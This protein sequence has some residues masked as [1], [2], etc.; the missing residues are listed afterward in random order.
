MASKLPAKRSSVARRFY[1]LEG[2]ADFV[3]DRG[4]SAA[5]EN[6]WVF[7]TSWEVANKGEVLP[8]FEV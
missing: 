4:A 5:E 2:S 1:R 8:S 6:I 3:L 7:E